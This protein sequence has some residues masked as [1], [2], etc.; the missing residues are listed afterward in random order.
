MLHKKLVIMVHRRGWGRRNNNGLN[1]GRGA[2]EKERAL[3]LY[4]AIS[5]DSNYIA[6]GKLN[7]EH[8]PTMSNLN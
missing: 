4:V 3:Q 8:R 7:G 2:G 5:Q 6:I 1:D